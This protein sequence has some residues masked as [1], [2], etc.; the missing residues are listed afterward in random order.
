MSGMKNY[1][2]LVPKDLY[3]GG[4]AQSAE[5]LF[6]TFVGRNHGLEQRHYPPFYFGN[7]Q[8][9]PSQNLADAFPAKNGFPITD[10]RS[11]YDETDPYDC[12]RDNRFDVNLTIRDVNLEPTVRILM[13]LRVE[14]TPDT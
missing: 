2:A 4:D 8:T 13:L 6:R 12:Q 1:S 14:K 9:T 11:L 10:S 7:A 3:D 5:F